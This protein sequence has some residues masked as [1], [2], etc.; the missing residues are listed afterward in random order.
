[1]WSHAYQVDTHISLHYLKYFFFCEGWEFFPRSRA[2]RGDRTQQSAFV[3]FYFVLFKSSLIKVFILGSALSFSSHLCPTNL[4]K[5]PPPQQNLPRP[6]KLLQLES[7]K[8]TSCLIRITWGN[9][10]NTYSQAS[11][12]EILFYYIRSRTQAR[13]IKSFR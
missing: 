7:R 8:I 10:L 2:L 9:F 4:H 5:S 11:P 13:A 12:T 1:M 3:L 6:P